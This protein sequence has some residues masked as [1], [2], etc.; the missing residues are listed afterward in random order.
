MGKVRLDC[1]K[2]GKAIAVSDTA[3]KA[4]CPGCKEVIDVTEAVAAASSKAVPEEA[5][6]AEPSGQET[7]PEQ[8]AP[9]T[10]VEA[11][12]EKAPERPS[13]RGSRRISRVM[14][15]ALTTAGYRGW[16]VT[17]PAAAVVFIVLLFLVWW[18]AA[19]M[20][21]SALWLFADATLSRV[22]RVI[23]KGSGSQH[24]PILWG[25]IGLVPV[26]GVAVYV[27][28]KRR[29]MAASAEDI[30]PP[31]MSPEEMEDAGKV[32]APSLLSP[33]VILIAAI[34]AMLI[35]FFWTPARYKV[36]VAADIGSDF[37]LIGVSPNATYNPGSVAV[38]LKAR[39]PILEF[40]KVTVE[41][42][43]LAEG[44][45]WRPL[46]NEELPVDVD[47][48]LKLVGRKIQVPEPG[49]YRVTMKR[50]DG[51]SLG[52]ADFSIRERR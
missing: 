45:T 37:R 1:P 5:P 2:C 19:I 38:R 27:L 44:G 41:V 15:S 28:L 23:P 18:L 40:D 26:A 3:K 20:V 48:K 12:P 13:R 52:S 8:K 29:L 6:A 4:R 33:G 7:S 31:S 22:T 47:A 24:V 49:R 9:A 32:P 43:K 50:P 17:I 21:A 39:E 25:L 16:Q 42:A 51:K 34:A 11:A 10:V 36:E 46:G 30:A 14:A 35:V